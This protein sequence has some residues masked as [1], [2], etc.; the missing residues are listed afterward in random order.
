MSKAERPINELLR[1]I[2]DSIWPIFELVLVSFLARCSQRS[3]HVAL[4]DLQLL[5][6]VLSFSK[7]NQTASLSNAS[8]HFI[9][10]SIVR[11]FSTRRHGNA[12][13][14]DWR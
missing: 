14:H 11:D 7:I 6:E 8:V 4:H 1:Y 9:G 10:P 12:E 2:S 3:K 13:D 5:R